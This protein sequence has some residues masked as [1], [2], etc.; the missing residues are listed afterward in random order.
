MRNALESLYQ[1]LGS[2]AELKRI[3]RLFYERMAADVMLGFFFF[4]R[5]LH[6]I[7]DRQADFLLRAMG[8]RSSY[9]GRPPAQAHDQ[10]PPI[11]PG[12]FDRR[13]VILSEVLRDQAIPPEL[14][15]AWL[16]FEAAFRDAVVTEQ[17]P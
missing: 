4:G 11:L 9:S 2:E 8:A 13:A 5:D 6:A 14:A 7:A 15:K 16:D 12:H 3:M 1:H 10:L 17:K